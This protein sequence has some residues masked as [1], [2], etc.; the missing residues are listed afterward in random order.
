MGKILGAALVP[1]PPILLEEIGGGEEKKANKTLEGLKK[2]SLFIKAQSPQ[3]IILITPHG[4]L[5][6]DAVSISV[7]ED[8]VG[9]FANFGE[10]K[11]KQQYKNNLNLVHR[12]INKSFKENIMVAE[13]DKSFARRYNV[14]NKLDHGALVPLYFVDKEYKNF[15]LI[16]ITYGLLS[17]KELYRFGNLIEEAIRETTE[18]VF[19]IASGDLSHKLSNDGP[20][21]YS[22]KG[23]VF[24]KKIVETISQGKIEDIINFDLELA[25][26]AGECGLRSLM[27]LTGIISN[28]KIKS[29][30]LSYEGPFGVG[31]CNAKIDIIGE[32]PEG[33]KDLLQRIEEREKA[34]FKEIRENEDS[35]VRLARMSLEHY[36]KEGRYLNIPNDIPR[37]LLETRKAVFVTLK[38][39]GMLRGC[40]GTTEPVEPNIALEIIRNAVSAGINDPR[41]DPVEE[42]ELDKLIYSVDVLSPPEQIKSKDELDVNRYGVI[43]SKGYKKGLLLPML[44][45]VDTVEEQINIALDK[46]G[47]RRNEDYNLERFEVIRHY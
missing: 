38:K 9:D 36:I 8:L 17:P 19:V 22:P 7:E 5:F 1:H 47:I 45:G 44:E 4:P 24:D 39:D 10:Q 30:I 34:K 14:E 11:I 26:S 13:V 25:E 40:I 46:A 21:T 29:E 6:R 15:K 12:I 37:E 18:N 42:D 28:Y 20:Y 31:Y 3:T 23:E 43:V 27:I 32:K 41:F 16:H 33:E 35:Y 2:I